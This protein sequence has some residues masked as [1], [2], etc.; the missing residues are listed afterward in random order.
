MGRVGR[1]GFI[2]QYLQL[3][4]GLSPLEAGLWTLPGAVG[5]MAGSTLTPLFVGRLRPAYVLGAGLALAG[6]GQA[7]LTQLEVGSGVALVVVSSLVAGLGI[8]PMFALA[9]DFVIGAAPPERAG[10]ASA[11]SET[12]NELGG[13]LGIAIL[14]SIGT[15]VYRG[16]IDGALPSGVPDDAAEATRDTLGGAVGASDALPSGQAGDVLDVARE[17]L[18]G[19]LQLTAAIGAA[20]LVAIAVVAAVALRRERIGAQPEPRPDPAPA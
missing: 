18:I 7:L 19:G 15:A 2:A 3:V 1:A 12:G 6:A 17:A 10:S 13:A 4:E 5:V 11:I 14:G 9:T 16:E 8:G 20:L